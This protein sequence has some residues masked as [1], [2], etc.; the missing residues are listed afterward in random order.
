V[1]KNVSCHHLTTYRTNNFDR[2]KLPRSSVL[3]CLGPK[4]P[5][6]K[7]GN[8]NFAD[9]FPKNLEVTHTKAKHLIFLCKF[10]ADIAN[11]RP[12]FIETLSSAS[13]IG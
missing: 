2:L 3:E 7:L 10:I 5:P 6:L 12:G 11:L 9:F 8:I 13:K 1:Y 4:K